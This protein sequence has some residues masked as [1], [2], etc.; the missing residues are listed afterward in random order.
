MCTMGNVHI[1]A[2]IHDTECADWCCHL[3]PW[4]YI[5]RYEPNT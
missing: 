3:A 4:V 2:W 1:K 5:W